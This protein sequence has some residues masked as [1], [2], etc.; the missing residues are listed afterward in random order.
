MQHERL[1]LGIAALAATAFDNARLIDAERRQRRLADQRASDLARSNAELEQFAYICS[2]DLQEPL[3]MVSSFLSLLDDRYRNVL[4]D[5][6]R[7]FVRRAIDGSTR[8]QKLVRDILAYSRVGRGEHA[9][10]VLA[11]DDV[12]D[13][14]LANLETAIEQNKA[15]IKRGILPKVRVN[16]LQCVQLFQNLISNALKF[17]GDQDPIVSIDCVQEGNRWQISITDNGIGID[18][19]HHQRIFQVFQRLHGRDQIDGTGIG[20]SLCQ[21]IVLAHGGKLTVNSTPGHGATFTFSLP[22]MH[23]V[24]NT[25]LSGQQTIVTLSQHH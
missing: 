1:L 24:D 10:E 9:E 5:R 23:E 15:E 21:K 18:P 6:G 20:L 4:D 16:R 25:P 19:S 22:D 11:L 17:H 2:H 12:V 3:R 7:D 13:E 14:A 8:M